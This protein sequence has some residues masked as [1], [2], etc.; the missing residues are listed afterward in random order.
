MSGPGGDLDLLVV[1]PEP[2]TL[3]LLISGALGPLLLLWRRNGA[4]WG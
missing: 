1:L 2:G 3:V 4:G